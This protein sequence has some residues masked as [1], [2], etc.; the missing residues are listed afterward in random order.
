M[1]GGIELRIR[2]REVQL[3]Q[4]EKQFWGFGVHGKQHSEVSLGWGK[5]MWEI[6]GLS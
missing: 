6:L 4:S 3:K 2:K 5:G 1:P